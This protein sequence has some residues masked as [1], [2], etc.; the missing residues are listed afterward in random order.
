M[1]LT[2][3]T[4]GV[5]LPDVVGGGDKVCWAG[6]CTLPVAGQL[7]DNV[8]AVMDKS[9]ADEEVGWKDVN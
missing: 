4:L 2:L 7:D 9:F 1:P 8:G 6:P 5:M 3:F